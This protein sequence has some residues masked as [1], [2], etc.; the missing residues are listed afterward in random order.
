L[1]NEMD[2]RIIHANY[3]NPSVDGRLTNGKKESKSL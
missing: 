1:N 3:K 2:N